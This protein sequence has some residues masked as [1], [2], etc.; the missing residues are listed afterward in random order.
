MLTKVYCPSYTPVV[1]YWLYSSILTLER[2]DFYA[3]KLVYDHRRIVGY[4]S[5]L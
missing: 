5:V 2:A 3:F 1:C 4:I